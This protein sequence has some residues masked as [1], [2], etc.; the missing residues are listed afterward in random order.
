MRVINRAGTAAI[1][2]KAVGSVIYG[3]K[4]ILSTGVIYPMVILEFLHYSWKMLGSKSFCYWHRAAICCSHCCKS[5]NRHIRKMTMSHSGLCSPFAFASCLCIT[6]KSILF[7]QPKTHLLYIYWK[8]C[9]EK[10]GCCQKSDCKR[11]A[12]GLAVYFLFLSVLETFKSTF[13][14]LS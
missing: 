2:C 9:V 12:M 5:N 10:C 3:I 4:C 1:S 13:S 8:C 11:D 6:E 7:P 14:Q